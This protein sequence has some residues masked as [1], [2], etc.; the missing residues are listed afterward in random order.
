M[1][2]AQDFAKYFLKIDSDLNSNSY[3][4]NLKLQK[5]LV[6]S[7]LVSLAEYGTLLFDDPIYTFENGCVAENVR[8]I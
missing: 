2:K 4:G 8:K 3:N 6:L 5:L 1:R 7:N